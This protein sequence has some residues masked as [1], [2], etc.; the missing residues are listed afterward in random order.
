M[1]ITLTTHDNGN[2]MTYDFSHSFY[3]IHV[4]ANK[5][6]IAEDRIAAFFEK[7]SNTLVFSDIATFEKKTT[8]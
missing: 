6:Q 7:K 5:V 3:Y 2:G 4:P 8:D 1:K